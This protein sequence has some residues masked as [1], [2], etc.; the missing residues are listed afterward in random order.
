MDIRLE[1]EP[2]TATSST[3]SWMLWTFSDNRILRIKAILF[4][5][6]SKSELVRAIRLLFYIPGMILL[7][8]DI[9]TDVLL[10]WLT[11][12]FLGQTQHITGFFFI[13]WDWKYC[14]SC[15][16]DRQLNNVRLVPGSPV[17]I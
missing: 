11:F 15:A 5:S 17:K 9:V 12:S 2:C 4:Y 7:M 13:F 6:N 3:S 8:V 1:K 14:E 10:L 16:V